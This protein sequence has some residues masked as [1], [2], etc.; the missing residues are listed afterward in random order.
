MNH[1]TLVNGR[2]SFTI[3]CDLGKHRKSAMWSEFSDFITQRTKISRVFFPTVYESHL[4][5]CLMA[6]ELLPR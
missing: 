2:A 3:L 1:H 6:L 4:A 5:H